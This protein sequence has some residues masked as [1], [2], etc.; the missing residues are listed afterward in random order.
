MASTL[1]GAFHRVVRTL[2]QLIVAGG[3]TALVNT[4]ASGLDPSWM[5]F[6]LA[7][8][9]LVVTA[10]QNYLEATNVIPAILK[11]NH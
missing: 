5:A 9:Q 11:N 1:T 2:L 7:G 3:L 8:W 4:F 10:A 6:V